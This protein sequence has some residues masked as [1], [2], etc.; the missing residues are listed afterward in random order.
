MKFW[1]AKLGPVLRWTRG[2]HILVGMV[3]PGIGYRHSGAEGLGMGI[4]GVCV[5]GGAWELAMPVLERIHR[6]WGGYHPWADVLDLVS[7]L[8]GASIIGLILGV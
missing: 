2:V 5:V 3:I 1:R 7:F 6:G 8:V 4:L